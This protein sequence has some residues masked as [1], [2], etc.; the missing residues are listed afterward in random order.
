LITTAHNPHSTRVSYNL[1]YD[2]SIYEVTDIPLNDHVAH[3]FTTAH[4][5]V[6]G[7]SGDVVVVRAR[8]LGGDPMEPVGQVDL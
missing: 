8:N 2:Y 4:P 6:F 5:D 3:Y 1:S 7:D